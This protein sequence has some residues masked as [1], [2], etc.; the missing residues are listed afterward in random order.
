M[1]PN[2]YYLVVETSKASLNETVEKYL[3]NGWILHGFPIIM[4]DPNYNSSFIYG[5]AVIKEDW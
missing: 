3:A 4:C 2:R 1:E 5:Q